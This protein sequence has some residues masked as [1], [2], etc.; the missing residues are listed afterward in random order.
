MGILPFFPSG[1]YASHKEITR[2][3]PIMKGFVGWLRI[4]ACP[5]GTGEPWEACR[6]RSNVTSLGRMGFPLDKGSLRRVCH[7]KQGALKV[8]GP[9]LTDASSSQASECGPR[10]PPRHI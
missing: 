10:M 1:T 8:A 5:E 6:Q 2:I 4:W 3:R 7:P 9:Q